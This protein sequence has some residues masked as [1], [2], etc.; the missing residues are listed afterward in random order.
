RENQRLQE[1]LRD[2]ESQGAEHEGRVRQLEADLERLDGDLESSRGRETELTEALERAK[3]RFEEDLLAVR[4]DLETRLERARLELERELASTREELS[5]EL[6][7]A[8]T[9]LSTSER[10]ELRI[11][12]LLEAA[13]HYA[14]RTTQEARTQ[15]HLALKKARKRESEILEDARREAKRV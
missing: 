3:T 15:A 11:Q 12:E 7:H 5:A 10:R 8:K 13:A 2:A 1:A 9:K 6:A 4:A 14:D